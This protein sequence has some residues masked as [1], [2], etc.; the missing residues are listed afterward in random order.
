MKIILSFGM[1]LI[2]SSFL[3]AQSVRDSLIFRKP[4]L[5]E[6]FEGGSV[7]MKSGVTETAQLNYNTD[8]QTIVFIKDNEYLTLTGTALI[9]TVYL[10]EKKYIPVKGIMYEVITNGPVTL[11]AKW[12]NKTHPEVA[13]VDQNGNIRKDASQVSNTVSDAYVGRSFKGNYRVEFF[14]TF[15]ILKDDNIYPIRNKKQLLKAFTGNAKTQMDDY[16]ED[17]QP[18]FNKEEDLVRLVSFCNKA[19][20]AKG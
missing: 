6:N 18:D 13:T 15:Y 11:L 1:F 5:L 10:E 3:M 4:L 12:N 14:R 20:K 7:L 8:N 17:H 16:V 2:S 19:G 9:D